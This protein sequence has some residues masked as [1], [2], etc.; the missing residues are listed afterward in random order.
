MTTAPYLV[1]KK[2]PGMMMMIGPDDQLPTNYLAG[3]GGP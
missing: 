3:G 1:G 2:G